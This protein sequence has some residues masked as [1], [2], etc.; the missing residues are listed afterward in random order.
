M[1][2]ARVGIEVALA[3]TLLS[4]LVWSM[5]LLLRAPA[6]PRDELKLVVDMQVIDAKSWEDMKKYYVLELVCISFFQ[7]R[8]KCLKFESI[9]S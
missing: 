1:M 6:F 8:G 3:S 7:R 9:I 5:S 4:R 2:A